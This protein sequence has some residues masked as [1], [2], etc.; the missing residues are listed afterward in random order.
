M[1]TETILPIPICCDNCCSINIEVRTNNLL[2]F[3][4][5]NDC[6]SS[7]GCHNGTLYPLG[8]MADIETR[9][10]RASA[11]KAFDPIWLNGYMTRTRAYNWL[12][13]LLKIE[14]TDCHISWLSKEQLNQ[15]IEF[16]YENS[17]RAIRNIEKA[18][19]EYKDRQNGNQYRESKGV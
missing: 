10:L 3:W 17:D 11:H 14:P 15:M 16:C 7:V 1:E 5:C 2:N 4:Y 6:Y 12:S 19:L 8:R 9:K 18:L 13:V